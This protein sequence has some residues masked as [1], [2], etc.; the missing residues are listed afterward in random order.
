MQGETA[1]AEIEAA[2]WSSAQRLANKAFA[3][4]NLER[5]E[6]VIE[7]C[8]KIAH[9]NRIEAAG[10]WGESSWTNE[11]I[12]VSHWLLGRSD[13]AVSAWR[14]ATTLST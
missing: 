2:T 11:M 6:E 4:L 8:Q 1:P 10:R 9:E 7:L 5:Y 3:L 12:G 13:E 14:Q